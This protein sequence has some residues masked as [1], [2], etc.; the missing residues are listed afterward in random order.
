MTENS[1]S[2][3]TGES[4]VNSDGEK[5]FLLVID[6]INQSKKI[7]IDYLHDEEK[8]FLLLSLVMVKLSKFF[9]LVM[10]GNL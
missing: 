7:P 4:L 5:F 2:V 10:C 8:N 9:V 1:R 3:F 6:S